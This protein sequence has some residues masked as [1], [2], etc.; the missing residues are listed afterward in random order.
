VFGKRDLPA[1]RL[2]TQ[3]RVAWVAFEE[4]PAGHD[5]IVGEKKLRAELEI[6][7]A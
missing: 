6:G 1:G 4:E 3:D 2:K 7:I 5:V